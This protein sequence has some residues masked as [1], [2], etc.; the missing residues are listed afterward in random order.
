MQV[1]LSAKA[2]FHNGMGG[3]VSK[4][5]ES[6]PDRKYKKFHGLS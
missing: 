2:Y 6:L 1:D 5:R 4:Y 3:Y